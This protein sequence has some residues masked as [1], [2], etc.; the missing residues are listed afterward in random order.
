MGGEPGESDCGDVG[1]GDRNGL[2]EL[3]G[4]LELWNGLRSREVE[5][6]YEAEGECPN[7]G[8]GRARSIRESAKSGSGGML[9]STACERRWG[10]TSNV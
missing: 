7:G 1:E 9:A 2:L 5:E 4:R 8:G 3:R 10:L 6:E